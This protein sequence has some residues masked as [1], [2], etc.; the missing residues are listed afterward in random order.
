[1]MGIGGIG[2]ANVAALLAQ[3]GYVVSGS[4]ER[5]YEPAAS[6]LKHAGIEVRTPYSESNL[7]SRD[8]P[9][10]VGNALSRGHAEVEKALRGNYALESFPGFLR[11]TVMKGKR[12]V[13]VA[14]THGKSTTTACIAHMFCASGVDASYLVGAQPVNLEFGGHAGNSEWFVIEGDEYDSAFFD[15]R[16]KFLD[17]FPEVLVL[18]TV[19]YDHADIFPTLEDML[20]SFRRLVAQLPDNGLLIANADCAETMRLAAG[21]RCRVLTV[22]VSERAEVR[23]SEKSLAQSPLG[24]IETF[25]PSVIGHH[26]RMNVAMAMAAGFHAGL[27]PEQLLEATLTFRGVKR[28]MEL[29]H[30]SNGLIVFDDFAHHPTAVEAA[31][32][33]LKSE[34]PKSHLIAVFEPRSNTTVR[35]IYQEQF[36]QSLLQADEIVIGS[37]HRRE[38]VPEADRLNPS[39]IIERAKKVGKPGAALENPEIVSYLIGSVKGRETVVLFMSN[40]SFDGVPAGFVRQVQAG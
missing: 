3:A 4:D 35:N 28:R 11:R 40:G 8:V 38:R 31:I 26:N 14:G 1:M 5:I 16:S 12:R 29:L 19:E 23:I 39:E 34:Y 25:A 17:Y 18:G 21:A 22:G 6:L 32:Q 33:A 9:I 36:T 2:M 24:S 13:V 15:K 37:V 20:L 10:I 7:P 27:S 30:S